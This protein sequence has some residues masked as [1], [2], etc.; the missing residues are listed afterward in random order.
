MSMNKPQLPAV[1]CQYG[2]PMGRPEWADDFTE[3]CRCFHV[4]FVDG[5]YDQGGS[6]W[7]APANLYCCTNGEG[8]QLFIRAVSRQDAKDHFKLHH[9][10]I[11]WVN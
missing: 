7:G 2:A 4:R 5:A 10:E 9:P 11:K 3:P 8:V 6:Y 1:N